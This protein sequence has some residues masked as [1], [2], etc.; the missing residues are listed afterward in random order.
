MGIRWIWRMVRVAWGLVWIAGT[1][2]NGTAVLG[3]AE[4][5]VRVVAMIVLLMSRA[6]G[7][8]RL[9]AESV[10]RRL[11]RLLPAV[12]LLGLP[13]LLQKGRDSAQLRLQPHLIPLPL[14]LTLLGALMPLLLTKVCNLSFWKFHSTIF[15][16]GCKSM[17]LNIKNDMGFSILDVN[18]WKW[19]VCRSSVQSWN[20]EIILNWVFLIADAS[21]KESLPRQVRAP[22]VF[23][24]IRV[25]AIEDGQNEYVY[26]AMVKINGHVFKGFLYDQGVNE[27]GSYPCISELQ[28]ET[29][30]SG[31]NVDSSSPILHKADAYDA[32]GCRGLLGGI[33]YCNSMV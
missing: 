12:A 33:P 9:A 25:T 14:F 7:C 18:F 3:C 10:R 2:L 30:A 16:Q 11:Q 22:A 13:L 1:R 4:L 27:K 31:R 32:S 19:W 20:W 29:N 23:R 24:C 5:V 15:F 21:F 8:P 26:Q 28:L 6:R 17:E